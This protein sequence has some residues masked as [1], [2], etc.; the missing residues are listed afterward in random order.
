MGPRLVKAL[1]WFV[2]GTVIVVGL[3]LII[4][5]AQAQVAN[6]C[7]TALDNLNIVRTAIDKQMTS[8]ETKAK[9]GSAMRLA[10]MSAKEARGYYA[11]MR[12]LL[13]LAC[14]GDQYKALDDQLID[15]MTK[16]DIFIQKNW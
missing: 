6:P 9:R 2:L 13:P 12:V 15:E 7:A 5:A 10:V 4:A 14:K 3:L 11:A 8:A 1:E 16:L